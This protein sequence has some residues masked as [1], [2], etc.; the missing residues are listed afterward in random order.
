MEVVGREFPQILLIHANQLN[1]DLMPDL[2]AMFRRRGY[3]FV[4]LE[5]AL[6]DPAYRL[7]DG[8][9]G[10]N[11]FSWIH[12]WSRTKGMK[13]KGEPDPPVVGQRVVA[14]LAGLQQSS[15]TTPVASGRQQPVLFSAA[16][17]RGERVSTCDSVCVTAWRIV[18]TSGSRVSASR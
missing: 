8:Y 16:R 12:R 17:R 13:P 6:A 18:S 15:V 14:A 10:R 1:A 9:A 3:T 2:L 5:Q 11:G 4:S 7:E